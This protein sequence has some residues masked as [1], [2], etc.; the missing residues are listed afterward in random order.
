MSQ[1]EG[2]SRCACKCLKR[3]DTQ[4]VSTWAKRNREKGDRKKEEGNIG[5]STKSKPDVKYITVQSRNGNAPCH[6]AAA[7]RKARR[8]CRAVS[9]KALPQ[10]FVFFCGSGK[11]TCRMFKEMA[12]N[13]D[14][15]A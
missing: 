9:D 4:K 3:L 14:F 6:L 10:L 13:V 8:T 12:G 1:G 11:H 7:R 5:G 2:A 15:L